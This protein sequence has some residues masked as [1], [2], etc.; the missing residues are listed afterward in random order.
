MT[1]QSVIIVLALFS[2]TLIGCATEYQA[3]GWMG[4][5]YSE[6]RIDSNTYRVEY[7][8]NEFTSEMVCDSYLF[9]R[10]AELTLKSGYDHFV[11]LDHFTRINE[12]RNVVPG[13]YDKVVTRKGNEEKTSYVYR[14]PYTSVSTNPI[15]TALIKMY[16]GYAPSDYT[17]NVFDA[18]EVLRYSVSEKR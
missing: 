7:E 16:R 10:C 9:R 14:P 8:C 2:L 17:K 11:M 1:R 15:S 12:K 4:D 5:G 13:H 6:A 18:R 3:R